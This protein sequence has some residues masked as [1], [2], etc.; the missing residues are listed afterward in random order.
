MDKQIY[1]RV[2]AASG[3]IFLVLLL[4]GNSIFESGN[5]SMGAA[6]E[7]VGLLSFIPFLGYLWSVL[8]QAEGEDGWLSATALA[9]GLAGITVKLGSA[10]PILAARDLQEG[11]PLYSALQGI[12]GASFNLTMLP[13]GVM[14]A[15][16]AIV[17]LKT[18]VLPVWLG[19]IGAV[20]APALVVN[21]A[22]FDAEFIPA[23]LLFLL[24][25]V[26]TSVVL[27]WRAGRAREK[28]SVSPESARGV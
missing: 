19:L 10:A 15:A 18:R 2:G 22:F 25:T 24:W 26:L 5:E 11:T 16:V 23:F 21:G 27:T 9:A 17:T 1:P 4:V 12:N 13:F 14:V 6:V 8:R 28:T 20:T 3:I 7:L